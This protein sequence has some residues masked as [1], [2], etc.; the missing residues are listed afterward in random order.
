MRVF[1]NNKG[2]DTDPIWV[3]QKRTLPLFGEHNPLYNNYRIIFFGFREFNLKFTLVY[4]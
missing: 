1:G 3:D 4:L 2:L